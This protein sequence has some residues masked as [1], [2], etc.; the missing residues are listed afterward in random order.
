MSIII[1]Y[2]HDDDLDPAE[3]QRIL[4]RNAMLD[5]EQRESFPAIAE[6]EIAEAVV[7]SARMRGLLAQDSALVR[8]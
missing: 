4:E 8:N 2:Q 6:R 1:T 5:A 3:A 7:A